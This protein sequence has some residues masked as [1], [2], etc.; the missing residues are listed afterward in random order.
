MRELPV[1]PD[2]IFAA[3]DTSAVSIICELKKAGIRV[4]EDIAIVGFNDV[5]IA[6]VIDPPLTTIHYPGEK[7]GEVAASTLIDI[8]N[9]P[10]SVVNQTIVLDHR[11][12]VRK[13]SLKQSHLQQVHA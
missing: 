6:K 8:L 10:G 9:S 11:L 5:H 4:P 12:V 2:G 1:T 13:S 7:M 3:N